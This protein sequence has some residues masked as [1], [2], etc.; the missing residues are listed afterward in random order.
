MQVNLTGFLERNTGAFMGELWSMCIS[1]Q[2]NYKVVNGKPVKG[3]PTQLIKEK[4]DEIKRI[5]SELQERAKKIQEEQERVRER[6]RQAEIER[7]KEREAMLRR[8][9]EMQQEALKR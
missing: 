9:V 8:Q 6:A 7:Q 1:A 3:M 4:E 5:N 2:E